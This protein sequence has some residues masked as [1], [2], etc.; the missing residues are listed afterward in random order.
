MELAMNPKFFTPLRYPGGKA[1]LGQWVAHL[2][3]TNNISGGHYVE[4]YAGGSGVALYLLL[5]GYVKRITIND[6]DPLIYNFWHTVL[7]RTDELIDLIQKTPVNIDVWYKQ[8]EIANNCDNFS[9]I[10]LGFAAFFLNRTNRSGILKGGVIGGLDQ[11][12]KYKI[13]ARFN[14]SDLIARIEKIA[15]LRNGIEL[16]QL[17][18]LDLIKR[19]TEQKNDRSLIYL[20]PPYYNKGSQLYRNFYTPDD[21]VHISEAIKQVTTP[22]LVT[23]DNCAE[24]RKLYLREQ[25]LE[26]SLI[27]SSNIERPMATELM[28]YGNLNIPMN[29]EL[30]KSIKPYPRQWDMA[31]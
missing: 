30:T 9:E 18:A 21:H 29:P 20:D 25:S 26:F 14:K 5:N 13:D 22:W 23:Y 19:H 27:Y 4:A 28:V 16:L 1:G 15:K 10:E 17:D 6:I 31:A 7:N 8:R 12:G 2:M 24:I 3:R 11:S